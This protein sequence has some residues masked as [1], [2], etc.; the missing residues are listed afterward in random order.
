MYTVQGLWTQAREGA[1]VTTVIFSNRRYNILDAELKSVGVEGEVGGAAR[2]L[3]TLND[4]DINWVDI[5]R[6]MGVDGK[7]A[8]TAEELVELIEYA[9]TR[10]GPFLI[11]AIIG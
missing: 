5:A 10:S 9:N 4:P 6:G 7:A 2:R 8:T 1:N 11:E 3:L